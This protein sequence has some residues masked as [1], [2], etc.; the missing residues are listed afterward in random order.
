MLDGCPLSLLCGVRV[1]FWLAQV[2]DRP[3]SAPRLCLQNLGLWLFWPQI[4]PTPPACRRSFFAVS[5]LC[6]LPPRRRWPWAFNFIP[7][8]SRFSTTV[9][10]LPLAATFSRHSLLPAASNPQTRCSAVGFSTRPSTHCG[11]WSLCCWPH[12]QP[13]S[14]SLN[15]VFILPG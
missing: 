1:W 5:P 4:S 8:S 13:P 14:P 12:P 10:T 6:L 3:C 11:V 15:T 9:F 7:L 2:L